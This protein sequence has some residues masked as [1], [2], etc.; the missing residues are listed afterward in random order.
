MPISKARSPAP[1]VTSL[2]GGAEAASSASLASSL[3]Y[4]HLSSSVP[5]W[6]SFMA[7]ARQVGKPHSLQ[8]VLGSSL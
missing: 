2:M 7:N 8:L 6:A 4:G 1:M 3:T 5:F